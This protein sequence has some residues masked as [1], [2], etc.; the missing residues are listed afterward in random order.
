MGGGENPN[1]AKKRFAGRVRRAEKYP[2]CKK[3]ARS[4]S[5]PPASA[6]GSNP[7]PPGLLDCQSP[8]RQ[9]H[10]VYFSFLCF[11]VLF[12]VCCLCFVFFCLFYLLFLGC[13]CCLCRLCA[14]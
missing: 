9:G 14:V 6:R 1:G 4:A 13:L 3:G 7:R 12:V 10:H 2:K 5:S 8:T 11:F